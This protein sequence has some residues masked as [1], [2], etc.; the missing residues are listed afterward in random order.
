MEWEIRDAFVGCFNDYLVLVELA[1]WVMNCIAIGCGI[2][3]SSIDNGRASGG[4]ADA[5]DLKSP[6]RNLMRVRIPPRPLK[7][8]VGTG[9]NRI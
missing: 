3:E 6:G 5:G 7:M 9:P 1:E 4:M 2:C 8:G